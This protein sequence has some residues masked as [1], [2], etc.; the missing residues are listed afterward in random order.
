MKKYLAAYG[1]AFL[2]SLIGLAWGLLYPNNTIILILA[3][4]SVLPVL[5]LIANLLLSKQYI[6]KIN[7]SKVA[8]M[9]SYMLRHRAEA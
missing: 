6:D 9:Q 4:L 7:R 2:I 3:V 1:S 8:D 5:F